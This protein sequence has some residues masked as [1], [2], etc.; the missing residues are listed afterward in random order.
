[1]LDLWVEGFDRILGTNETWGKWSYIVSVPAIIS[2]EIKLE[3]KLSMRVFEWLVIQ[4]G[5]KINGIK[6][7]RGKWI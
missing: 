7:L 4:V 1:M 3:N 5:C 2:G 6:E